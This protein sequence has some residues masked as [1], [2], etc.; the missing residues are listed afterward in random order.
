MVLTAALPMASRNERFNGRMNVSVRTKPGQRGRGL[1]IYELKMVCDESLVG[2]V[3][4]V[5]G[6]ANAIAF[7]GSR[8]LGRKVVGDEFR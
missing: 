8:I 5:I 7:L 3:R 2:K 4:V 6:F 1:L